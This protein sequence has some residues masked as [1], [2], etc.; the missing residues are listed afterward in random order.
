MNVSS[1]SSSS[2]DDS[3]REMG[4]SHDQTHDTIVELEQEMEKLSCELLDLQG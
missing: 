2:L 4:I 3:G 1:L